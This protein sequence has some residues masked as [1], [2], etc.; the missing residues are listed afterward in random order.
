M[1]IDTKS[2]RF[3]RIAGI[4]IVAAIS[5]GVSIVC[6]YLAWLQ[7]Q[8]LE[9]GRTQATIVSA[10]YKDL[11]NGK[12]L[13]LK[14]EYFVDNK[15]YACVVEQ[16]IL[17]RDFEPGNTLPITYDPGNPASSSYVDDQAG[18][19]MILYSAFSIGL[20]MVGTFLVLWAREN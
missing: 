8:S 9:W 13:K 1:S 7:F 2:L 6:A 14:Y 3:D 10:E 12:H 20:F 16:D 19:F 18:P 11:E 17:E 15:K 4:L 5:F